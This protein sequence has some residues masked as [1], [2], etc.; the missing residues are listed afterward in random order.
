MRLNQIW[1]ALAAVIM[2]LQPAPAIGAEAPFL[3][4]GAALAAAAKIRHPLMRRVVRVDKIAHQFL[5]QRLLVQ[6]VARQLLA[7]VDM[8]AEMVF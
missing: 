7:G 4:A 1:A 8:R 6:E 5:M 2:L 3:A